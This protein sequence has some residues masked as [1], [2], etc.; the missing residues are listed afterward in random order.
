MG[1]EVAAKIVPNLYR[2]LA[3]QELAAALNAM[4][5]PAF[6]PAP[7]QPLAD[8]LALSP[9]AQQPAQ[10]PS[11]EAAQPAPAPVE[12][13]K[14]TPKEPTKEEAKAPP[15]PA[16]APAPAEPA[17]PRTHTVGGDDS[18][19]SL[20]RRY[21]GDAN[22][23]PEIFAL[24]RDQI[25]DPNL[26]IDGQVLKIPGD[27]PQEAPPAA[28]AKSGGPMKGTTSKEGNALPDTHGNATTF[29]N[30]NYTYK[31]KR[32]TENMSIGAWGDPNKPE[33]FFCALPVGLN[34]GGKW[35]HNQKILVTNPDNGKQVVV[36]VQDKGPHPRTGNK[37]DLSPVA[38]E[39]LG[40]HFMD[41]MN[42]DIAFAPADAPV[43]PVA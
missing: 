15:A 12:A 23:W 19:S 34:G 28:V 5:A 7:P 17:R 38:K 18:L 20:A 22:R 11:P 1:W 32:D 39:A 16:P 37:I 35:W 4:P 3:Q 33:Q 26:I 29:W 43:G 41:N 8:T 30:G 42:V 2:N 6:M 27:G 9:A 13:P 36:L 14:E 40:V 31:G 21:L 10:P 25:K 24:N